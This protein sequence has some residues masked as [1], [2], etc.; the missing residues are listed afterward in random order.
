M[1]LFENCAKRSSVKNRKKK[2]FLESIKK[3][4]VKWKKGKLWKVA[5]ESHK[6]KVIIGRMWSQNFLPTFN[7]ASNFAKEHQIRWF[8]IIFFFPAF[9]DEN[10]F[11]QREPEKKEEKRVKIFWSRAKRWMNVTWTHEWIEMIVLILYAL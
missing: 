3:K 7:C 9:D 8:C 10:F 4:I 11:F 5:K 6:I 2:I 1:E